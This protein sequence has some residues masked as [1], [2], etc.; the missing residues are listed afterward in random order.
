M[1]RKKEGVIVGVGFGIIAILI[2]CALLL[3][4]SPFYQDPLYP[5]W[6]R[7]IWQI[8]NIPAFAVI[9][10]S[11]TEASGAIVVFGQWFLIGF[12]STWVIFTLKARFQ[13]T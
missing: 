4:A 3:E 10:I 8:M 11:G 5:G 7:F 6:A 1:F 9:V 13:R 2:S 12:A